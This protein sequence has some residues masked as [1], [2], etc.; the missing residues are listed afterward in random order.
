[1]ETKGKRLLDSLLNSSM[2]ILVTCQ[3]HPFVGCS[4]PVIATDGNV[5]W[6]PMSSEICV[7]YTNDDR[8]KFDGCSLN[9]KELRA[10]N[11]LI[12]SVDNTEYFFCSRPDYLKKMVIV[13]KWI[14]E[15]LSHCWLLILMIFWLGVVR[16]LHC[17]M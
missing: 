12:L 3:G 7:C 14:T 9:H 15:R 6:M 8:H 16:F 5:L 2:H 4:A 11:K 13:E 1:M 10:V 17:Q